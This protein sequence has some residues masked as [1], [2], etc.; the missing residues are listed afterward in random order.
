MKKLNKLVTGATMA[1]ALSAAS[2]VAPSP[3]DADMGK[4]FFGAA[5]TY[6]VL[7]NTT[8]APN[9]ASGAACA[10]DTTA[11][12]NNAII[13]GKTTKPGVW[14]GSSEHVR[15]KVKLNLSDTDKDDAWTNWL[16]LREV[17]AFTAGDK[18][19]SQSQI[20]IGDSVF[21]NGGVYIMKSDSQSGK[22]TVISKYNSFSTTPTKCPE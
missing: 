8:Y 4:L 6:G 14:Y 7:S 3:A 12:N 9:A 18:D 1:A 11:P 21:Y 19:Q 16:N 15:Y 17:R 13:V 20:N 5:V 2:L 22:R 10:Q